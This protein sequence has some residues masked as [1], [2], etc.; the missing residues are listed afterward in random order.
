MTKIPA[1]H[2]P[3]VVVA[4]P[5]GTRVSLVG[6]CG[7]VSELNASPYWCEMVEVTPDGQLG[8]R[9]NINI[10]NIEYETDPHK[11]EII[12]RAMGSWNA[13]VEVWRQ[14]GVLLELALKH[15]ISVDAVLS[16]VARVLG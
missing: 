16:I 5:T 4:Q 9:G 14:Q 15:N 12:N 11:C 2:V 1:L 6:A 8:R 7:F 3:I 10:E 13:Q